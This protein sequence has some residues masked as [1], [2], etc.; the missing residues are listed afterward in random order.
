MQISE[1]TRRQLFLRVLERCNL[2]SHQLREFTDTKYRVDLFPN[3]NTLIFSKTQNPCRL[4]RAIKSAL[5]DK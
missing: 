2:P 5:K 1:S 4:E 3:P